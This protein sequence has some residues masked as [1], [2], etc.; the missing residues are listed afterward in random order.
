M[1][2]NLRRPE[3]VSHTLRDLG[4]K[5]T[6]FGVISEYYP[7]VRAVLLEAFAI[8][9]K[10]GWTVEVADAWDEAFSLVQEMM[11]SGV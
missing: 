9:M 7:I 6:S 4:S 5:H 11:L 1:V 10:G 3:A 2:E 8:H